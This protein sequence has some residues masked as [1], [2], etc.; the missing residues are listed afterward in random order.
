[1]SA[2]P[3]LISTVRDLVAKIVNADG[4][5]NKSLG[6][7]APA[8]GS[9]VKS[10]IITSDDTAAQTLQLIKTVAAVDYILGEIAVPAG[11][12]TD[13]A[14]NGVNA[15]LSTGRIKGLQ[16]DGISTWIDVANGTTLSLKSKVAVTAGKTIYLV[17]EAGDFT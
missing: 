8:D 15:F 5:A 17:A 3:K 4:T 10:L 13:G 7:A 6:V 14:S 16:T 2:N 1:M 11:S 12:G 9:R